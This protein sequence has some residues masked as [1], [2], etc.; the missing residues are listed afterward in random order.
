MGLAQ[1]VLLSL[2]GSLKDTADLPGH[3]QAVKIAKGSSRHRMTDAATGVHIGYWDAI[4]EQLWS[5]PWRFT[6]SHG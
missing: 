4:Q 2:D 6:M 3:L 1:Y 5:Y